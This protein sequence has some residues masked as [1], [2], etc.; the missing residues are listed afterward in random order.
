[1]SVPWDERFDKTLRDALPLLPADCPL[2]DDTRLGEHGMDSMATIETMLSLEEQYGVSFPDE[3][4]TSETFATPGSL[5][6]VLTA[7]RT[8]APTTAG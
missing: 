5:W 2:E 7:L 8:G 3:A 4:L 6:T 1:M